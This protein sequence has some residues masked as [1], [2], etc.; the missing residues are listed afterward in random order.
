MSEKI[1]I[2][3]IEAQLERAQED[4]SL[5]PWVGLLLSMTWVM[6]KGLNQQLESTLE[7]LAVMRAERDQLKAKLYGRKSEQKPSAQPKAEEKK[8]RKVRDPKRPRLETTELPE[9]IREHTAPAACPKCGGHELKDLNAPEEQVEYV[10]RPASLVRVRHRL[11]KCACAKGCTVVTAPA[12]PR[13][14]EGGTLFGPSVYAH[15]I[16]ARAFDAMPFSRQADRW[17]RAG[18]PLRK[19]TLC[20]LFH[21]G[22]AELKPLYDVLLHEV[23]HAPLVHADETPQPFTAEGKTRRGYFWVFAHATFSVYVFSKTRSGDVPK[24]H[25]KETE[26]HLV[27][28]GYTGYNS[29]TTP[30]SRKRVGCLA[31]MRRKFHDAQS[32]DDEVSPQVLSL[33]S[34]IYKVEAKVREAGQIGTAAHLAA[35]QTQS[36]PF[37]EQLKALIAEQTGRALP[38]SPLGKALTYAKNQWPT[39]TLFLDDASLPLDNNHAERLLRRAALARKTSLFI[40]P[41]LG[42]SY[43]IAYSLVQSCRLCGLNPEVYLADVLLRIQSTPQHLIRSLLPDRWEPPDGTPAVGWV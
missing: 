38:K 21:R 14:G 13:V 35:R 42:E 24:V 43:A 11:Q 4:P 41:E 28:D 27:V 5:P 6:L 16:A 40:K 25:L 10:M 20:D 18:I 15:I 36:R 33:V 7:Q 8:P 2:T 12:P 39:L 37:M 29:V 22:C 3:E 32:T 30:K 1:T 26:G 19:S 17:S 31:H 23:S 9:E 34:E